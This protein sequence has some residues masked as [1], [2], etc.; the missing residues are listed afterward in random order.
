MPFPLLLHRLAAE[1]LPP[2]PTLP[3]LSRQSQPLHQAVGNL[4]GLPFQ[5]GPQVAA[6]DARL[7]PHVAVLV[8]KA[9]DAP[10]LHQGEIA[11]QL[12]ELRQ[13]RQAGHEHVV[14]VAV[15]PDVLA[16]FAPAA[17]HLPLLD[18]LPAMV[19]VIAVQRAAPDGREHDHHAVIELHAFGRQV[20]VGVAVG[21]D[22]LVGEVLADFFRDGVDEEEPLL[23]GALFGGDAGAADGGCP[24]HAQGC[25]TEHASH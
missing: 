17:E 20:A 23:G 16:Q 15:D 21:G 7:G 18:L 9:D 10:L 22:V 1:A 24:L 25:G 11:S 12:G 8:V 5:L 13:R 6:G 14:V 3:F 2:R 19:V 4:H